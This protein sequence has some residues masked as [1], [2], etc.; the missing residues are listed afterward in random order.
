MIQ[1]SCSA[2]VQRPRLSDF[3]MHSLDIERVATKFGLKALHGKLFNLSNL[4]FQGEK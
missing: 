1:H 4:I 3:R 2:R